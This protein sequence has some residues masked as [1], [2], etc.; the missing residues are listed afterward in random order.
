MKQKHKV[1]LAVAAAWAA[2]VPAAADTLS[3]ASYA[4]D[5][6]VG[7]WDGI[8]N[9]G[10]GLHDSTTNYWTDA[11]INA[12]TPRGYDNSKIVAIIS[13]LKETSTVLTMKWADY[14]TAPPRRRK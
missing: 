3:A 12:L 13:R 2:V 11:L 8:E 7:Q 10:A 14:R 9:V 4:Q 1:I 5:G 6:L